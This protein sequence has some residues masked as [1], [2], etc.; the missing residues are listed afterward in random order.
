MFRRFGRH[1]KEGFIG[2][3]RHFSMALSSIASVTITLL[4]IGLFLVLVVN[5]NV[6]TTEVESSISLSALVSYDVTSSSELDNIKTSIERIEGVK[7]ANYQ[8][9]DDEFTFYVNQYP[10]L[11]DFYELY[12]SDNPFHDVF[13]VS[14]DDGSKLE[15]VKVS[16]ERVNGIDS[17]HDGGSNT[18]VLISALNK[19]RIFGG[20]LVLGL[21][22]LAVYLIYN[23]IHITIEAR[24]TEIWIMRNVGAKNGFIRAPFLVE[25]VIIGILGSI[26]PIGIIIGGYLYAFDISG[27][28]ILGVFDL[29]Q[30]YPFLLYLSCTLL[31][32]G[33]VVGFIGS[34]FSV[35]RSLRRTR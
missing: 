32:I 15:S 18:Y 25:G 28:I 14:V 6:L 33:V 34:Y 21:T 31:C 9:K 24:E 26:I 27:G 2:I 30:P 8:S 5:L 10:D 20:I 22:L 1:I 11:S 12:R 16:L 13:L 23:T 29:L 3:G 4:L 35:T 19:I 17:V 7:E